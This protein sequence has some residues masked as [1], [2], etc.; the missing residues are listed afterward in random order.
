MARPGPD[1]DALPR[2]P[3]IGSQYALSVR[4]FK[5][6]YLDGGK[7]YKLTIPANPPVKNFWSIVVRE[8]GTKC[9]AIRQ[10]TS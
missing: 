2:T 1:N 9:I 6:E 7:T 5:G 3:R 4:D 8:E 10:K